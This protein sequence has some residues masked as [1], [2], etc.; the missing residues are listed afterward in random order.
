MGDAITDLGSV[1]AMGMW[2]LEQ[3]SPGAVCD[4]H[5]PGE[6]KHHKAG[7]TAK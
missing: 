3:Q 6:C 4:P 5:M 7:V 2:D 1:I